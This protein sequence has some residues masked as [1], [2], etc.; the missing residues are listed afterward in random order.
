MRRLPVLALLTVAAAVALAVQAGA[1][2]RVAIVPGQTVYDPALNVTWLADADLPAHDT[3]GVHGIEK[4]GSM[5]YATAVAWVHAL[6]AYGGGRGYLGHHNWM[7]PATPTAPSVDPTC[8]S[9]DHKF[10][11][12]CFGSALGSL[13]GK[14]LGLHAPDTAV[15]IPAGV[16]GPFRNFQPYLYWTNTP[17]KGGHVGFKTFSFNTGWSGA[18]QPIHNMYVLPVITGNPFQTPTRN[19]K[20]LD[21]SADGKTVYDPGASVTWLADADLAKTETF[22]VPGIDRDGSMQG[23]TAAAWI[24]AMNR[25]AWLG[26]SDWRIPENDGC[27]GWNCGAK[28]GPLG[29]L[30]YDAL[31][32]RQG[33]PV[34]STPVVTAQR[35]FR[36]LQPYLYWSCAARTVQ[37]P[38]VGEPVPNQGSFSFG[39]GFKGTD[40]LQNELYVMVYYPGR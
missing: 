24:K 5:D 4:A 31:G 17:G 2:R 23:A 28:A 20:G 18:N 34:V 3:F 39:N 33:T 10:G 30:Y 12:G 25:H 37:G 15:P 1:A 35:G 36:E 29:Q 22:G 14:T 26:R 16:R 38:C 32:L 9:R 7:L 40:L 11:F 21:P 6:N 8:S 13:Y 27:G 19:G